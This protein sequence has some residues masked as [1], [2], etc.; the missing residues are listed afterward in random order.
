VHEL[1]IDK[2]FI[3]SLPD[4]EDAVALVRT[5][6]QLAKSLSLTTVAEGVETAAQYRALRELGCDEVQG[7]YVSRPTEWP[8]VMALVEGP[9]VWCDAQSTRSS[10]ADRCG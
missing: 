6:I 2:S 3:A 7:F 8:D 9:Q 1:K 5:I 10:A 4:D